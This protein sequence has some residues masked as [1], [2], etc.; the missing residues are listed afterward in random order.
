[1]TALA[2]VCL[3]AS[4]VAL[5]AGCGAEAGGAPAGEAELWITR[6]RGETVLLETR[7]AAGQT[8]LEALRGEAEVETT[9]GGRFV[10]AIDGL[11]GSLDDGTDWFY[12]VNGLLADRSAAEY[13]LRPDDVAW[14]DHRAWVEDRE[15][16]AAVVG[17]F[18]EP[19][20]H[21]YDG[22]RLP[23]AVVYERPEQEG[24]ARRLAEVLGAETVTT[25]APPADA[26]VLVLSEGPERF[27]ASARG[28]GGPVR[29]VFSGD[30]DALAADPR[31]YRFRFEV[32]E[33]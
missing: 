7:V 5:L 27:R 18:P 13:R 2:R 4:A 31:R 12:F 11:S 16:V 21:G 19:F 8:V 9:H 32:G 24:A 17:A 10:Q 25:G 30:A 28:A 1:M 26:N 20:L 33:E 22:R 23:A 6:D 14:W 29:F 3:L 15:P